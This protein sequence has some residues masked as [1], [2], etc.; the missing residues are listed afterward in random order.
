M[1]FDD[2]NYG[3]GIAE[4]PCSLYNILTQYMSPPRH[5]FVSALSREKG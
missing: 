1:L 2:E 4:P 5:A 3:K